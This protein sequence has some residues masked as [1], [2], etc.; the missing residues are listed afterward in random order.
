[1]YKDVYWELHPPRVGKMLYCRECQNWNHDQ[2][3]FEF[4]EAGDD[5]ATECVLFEAR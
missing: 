2:C 4:P 3:G 5:F 1:M